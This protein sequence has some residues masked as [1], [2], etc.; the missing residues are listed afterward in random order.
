MSRLEHSRRPPHPVPLPQG[1]RGPLA[2]SREKW[3]KLLREGQPYG[4]APTI[5][6]TEAKAM[7]CVFCKEGETRPQRVTVERHDQAGEPIAVIHNFPAEVCEICGE[8]Y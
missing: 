1:E 4:A 6:K 5:P 7:K 3:L 8:E 2:S